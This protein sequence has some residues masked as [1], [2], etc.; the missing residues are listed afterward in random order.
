MMGYTHAAVGV[1]SG[2]ATAMFVGNGRPETIVTA[3]ALGALGGIAADIDTK[4]QYD[5]PKMTDAGRTRLAVVGMLIIAMVTDFLL[6][7]NLLTYINLKNYMALGGAAAFLV[8]MVLGHFCKHRTFTHSLLF[9]VLTT[10]SIYCINKQASIF[11]GVGCCSHLILDIINKMGIPLFFP[12]KAGI[13]LGICGASGITANRMLYY[14][15]LIIYVFI[16]AYYIY[17]IRDPIIVLMPA[18]LMVYVIIV[19]FLVRRK[20][21][22]QLRH[23]MHIKGE[24]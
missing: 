15:G 13:K 22:R 18:V 17:L 23:I 24:L 5:N 9:V 16:S 6:D 20:S 3:A 21:E 11:Y 2:L 8:L 1:G 19:L 4:D 14:L 12:I 7:N 10:A